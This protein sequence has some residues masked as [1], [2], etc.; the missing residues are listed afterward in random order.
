MEQSDECPRLL[1]GV[2]ILL[3][4]LWKKERTK[5]EQSDAL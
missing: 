5:M 2:E 1:I 3:G 4:V